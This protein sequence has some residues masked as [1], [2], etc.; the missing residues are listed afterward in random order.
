VGAGKGED[1]PTLL[2]QKVNLPVINAGVR[3]DTTRDALTRIEADV[4]QFNPRLVIV[5]L[6]GNDFLQHVP[7][8]ETLAN[9]DKIV[10][11]TQNHGAMVVMATVN[12]GLVRDKYAKG[13][14]EIAKRKRALLVPNIMK[15]ILTDPQL[16]YDQIHPNAQGYKI[17]ADRLYESIKPLL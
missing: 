4:L 15:G 14:R 17:I 12:I 8:K 3:G 10:E 1:Y 16:K 6:G 5:I 9:I 11:R 13:F 7:E 2:S